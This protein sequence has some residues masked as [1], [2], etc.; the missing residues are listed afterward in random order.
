MPGEVPFRNVWY[1]K[2]RMKP[3]VPAPHNSPM[4]DGQKGREAASRLHCIYMRPWTLD[5]LTATAD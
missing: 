2:K 4:P 1:M 5:R 3:M